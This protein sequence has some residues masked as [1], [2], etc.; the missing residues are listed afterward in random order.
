MA[1]DNVFLQHKI[2]QVTRGHAWGRGPAYDMYGEGVVGEL[3]GPDPESASAANGNGNSNGHHDDEDPDYA[4]EDVT[5]F[6]VYGSG[7]AA[8]HRGA[9][10]GNAFVNGHAGNGGG[11]GGGSADA[12]AGPRWHGRWLVRWP[13]GQVSSYS[14]GGRGGFELSFLTLH[15]RAGE[16]GCFVLGM[17]RRG[18]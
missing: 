1:F 18:L 4:A 14:V 3:V 13:D 6:P 9:G 15:W 2:S 5:D 11:G 16:G 7:D 8:A 10:T 12:E 17:A